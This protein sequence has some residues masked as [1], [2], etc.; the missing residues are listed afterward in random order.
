MKNGVLRYEFKPTKEQLKLLDWERVILFHFGIRSFYID[1]CDRDNQK[2][3]LSAFHPKSLDCEQWIREAKDAGFKYTI[4][5]C[6]HQDGFANRPSK[7]TEYS[8]K[9]T[10]WKDGKGALV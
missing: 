10:L 8:V 5:T 1:H 7:Y 4:P 3:S 9:N 2:M 6:K